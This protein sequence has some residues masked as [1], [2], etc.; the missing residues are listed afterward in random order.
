MQLASIRQRLQQAGTVSVR[1]LAGEFQLHP[2]VLLE[3][4][5]PWLERGRIRLLPATSYCSSRCGQCA[6]SCASDQLVQWC[7]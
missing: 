7:S 6:A 3:R 2:D 5:Q 4:L 1:Q